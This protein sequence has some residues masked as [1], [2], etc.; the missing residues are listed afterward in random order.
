MKIIKWKK[1]RENKSNAKAP[2]ERK[3]FSKQREK[4]RKI[5]RKDSKKTIHRWTKKNS[6]SEKITNLQP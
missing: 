6:I 3:Y 4:T 2:T 5:D 1:E